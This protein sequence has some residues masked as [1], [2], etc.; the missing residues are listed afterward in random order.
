MG[1]EA[2]ADFEGDPRLDTVTEP[3]ASDVVL[4]SFDSNE[5]SATSPPVS[6][7]PEHL[8]LPTTIDS[9]DWS[10]FRST[11]PTP[12]AAA[13]ERVEELDDEAA[14]EP[15]SSRREAVARCLE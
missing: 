4:L 2:V 7:S 5:L 12:F 10:C 15:T 1:N 3:L 14:P 11:L 6:P 13:P 8:S 9:P